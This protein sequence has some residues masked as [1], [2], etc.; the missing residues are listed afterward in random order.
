MP[1]H[2]EQNRIL[3]IWKHPELENQNQRLGISKLKYIKQKT[4][5]WLI[6]LQWYIILETTY[7]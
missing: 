7:Q 5:M 2:D 6:I 3:C 1:G 4:I